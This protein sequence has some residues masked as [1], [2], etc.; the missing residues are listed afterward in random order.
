M[1]AALYLCLHLRDFAAQAVARTHPGLCRGPLLILAGSPPLEY[2]F[3]LNDAAR[4]QGVTMGMS[5]VQAESFEGMTI[6]GRQRI[7]EDNAF[8]ALITIANHFSPRVQAIAAPEEQFSAATFVLD[9]SNSERLLG[10][11]GRITHSLLA[12]VERAGYEAS[13]A[14]AHNVYA[15]VLAARGG[16]GIT[17][18]APGH[19]AQT[20]APLPLSVL[21]LDSVQEQ[22]FAAWGIH[23]LGELSALPLKPLVARL[24][25]SGHRLHLLA[26]GAYDH[27]LIPVEDAVDAALSEHVELEQPVELLEPLLF[28]MSRTLERLTQRAQER[29]L[30]IASVETC[31]ALADEQHSERRRMVRPALP[32][33]D[34]RTLL[35]LVQLDLELHPP[36]AGITAFTMHAHPARPRN[37]QQGLFVSQSPEA[38]R[39][40]ILLA[41][42]RKLVGE[43]RVGS[44]ELLD[45]HVPDAFRITS[46]SS[47]TAQANLHPSDG[48]SGHP[49]RLRISALRMV[50]PPAAVHMAMSGAF[51]A[52]LML[53]GKN[54]S[55]EMHSGPWRTSGAW[56]SNA[57]WCREEWDVVLKEAQQ[58]CL[59]LAYDPGA[60]CWYLIGIYD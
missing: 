14:V 38:G 22:T 24:G 25:K 46:F 2:V 16:K 36:R 18:I 19:E 55:I 37:A 54:F 53:D 1:P 34:F 10:T 5:R 17:I 29:A 15:A 8:A 47:G 30:A 57:D 21:E 13:I 4:Q 35:K 9:V 20:L 3:G 50:R 49:H 32:E 28:L 11:A 23:T 43:E 7:Q 59:R 33:H 52:A 12:E 40:E 56:W 45:S 6:L 41:R 27:L 44:A 51:P 60:N 58:R 26:R 42:L 31:L 39:L 48:K